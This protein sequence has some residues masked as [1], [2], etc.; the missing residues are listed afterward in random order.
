MNN[1]LFKYPVKELTVVDGDTVK[2]L[3][4]RGW[5]DF[6][7]TS[8]RI[9]GIDSPESRTRKNLLEREAGKLVTRV[10]QGWVDAWRRREAIFYATSEE[11]PKY[12]GRTVGSLFCTLG[13]LTENLSDY[14]WDL[15]LVRPYLGGKK[16]AWSDKE[17]NRIIRT[18]NEIL[19]DR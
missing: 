16:L 1:P 11:K 18:A 12:H 7:K 2:V 10:V 17:L 4:D 6:K 3:L 19:E 8:L 9:N 15:E 5:G 14:L 13:S